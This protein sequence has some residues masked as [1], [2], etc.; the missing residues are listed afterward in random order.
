MGDAPVAPR[1]IA[2][3]TSMIRALNE[4]DGK[5]IRK[6]DRAC[7]DL[8]EDDGVTLKLMTWALLRK[9][10]VESCLRH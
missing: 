5:Q 6:T 9:A 7:Q 2:L 3:R 10:I 4:V 1:R 8:S